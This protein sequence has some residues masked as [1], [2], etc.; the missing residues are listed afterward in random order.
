MTFQSELKGTIKDFTKEELVRKWRQG[1]G[2]EMDE[3]NIAL[4]N[5]RKSLPQWSYVYLMF[6]LMEEAKQIIS[7]IKNDNLENTDSFTKDRRKNK[8]KSKYTSNILNKQTNDSLPSGFKSNEAWNAYTRKVVGTYS[9]L[10]DTELENTKKFAGS[11]T[12]GCYLYRLNNHAH[13]NCTYL[14][15]WKRLRFKTFKLEQSNMVSTRK[16]N[17]HDTTARKSHTRIQSPNR[18]IRRQ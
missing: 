9:F 13:K 15:A 17:T 18:S 10:N 2:K 14:N 11:F 12:N 7:T 6:Q 3:I 1:L 8:E 5:L 4:D 16:S